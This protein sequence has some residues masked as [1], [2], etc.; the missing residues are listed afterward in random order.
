MIS[1]QSLKPLAFTGI[2]HMNGLVVLVFFTLTFLIWGGTG[3]SIAIALFISPFVLWIPTTQPQPNPI[4]LKPLFA[5]LFAM[6]LMH[7]WFEARGDSFKYWEFD[8]PSRY[9]LIIPV[10]LMMRKF[11]LPAVYFWLGVYVA[12]IVCGYESLTYKGSR[13]WGPFNPIIWGD[14][15]L[16][17]A[18]FIAVRLKSCFGSFNN[19][20]HSKPIIEAVFWIIPLMGALIGIARSGSRGAWLTI[21]MLAGLLIIYLLFKAGLKKAIAVLITT[22]VLAVSV[23]QAPQTT[24]KNRVDL[25]INE[26]QTFQLGQGR[27]TSTGLRLEMWYTSVIAFSKNPLFGLGKLGLQELE[28]ELLA[29]G[30]I[31]EWVVSQSSQQHSD[32]LDSLAKGGLLGVLVLIAFYAALLKLAT[33]FVDRHA[34]TLLLLLTLSYIGFGIT[35]TILVGMNGTMFLLGTLA[36]I[37]GLESDARHKQARVS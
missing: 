15:A 37:I 16:V 29:E 1:A 7:Y 35:N 23:Y 13:I 33:T 14:I 4:L 32:V 17:I 2:R 19:L 11:T 21:L 9:L 25:V 31:H 30:K 10:L 12:G 22:I 24:I 34:R 8:H 3:Y 20:R 36:A 28:E 6:F 5:A 26:L 18:L 27:A